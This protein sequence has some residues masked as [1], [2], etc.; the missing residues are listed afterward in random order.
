[1]KR[2]LLAEESNSAGFQWAQ[3]SIAVKMNPHGATRD[4]SKAGCNRSKLQS[5]N[6]QYNG[7]NIKYENMQK[8]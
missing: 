3:H 1:M 5:G 7:I 6:M 4:I 8:N 2:C